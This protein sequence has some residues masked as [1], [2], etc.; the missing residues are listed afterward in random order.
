MIRFTIMN[1]KYVDNEIWNYQVNLLRNPIGI[2]YE[3]EFFETT[4]PDHKGAIH[5]ELF[6][7]EKK[8]ML[9]GR[10]SECGDIYTF[11]AIIEKDKNR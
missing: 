1:H 3:G 11:W 10:W 2:S 8:H 7:N 9:Y 4:E 5:C 6:Q